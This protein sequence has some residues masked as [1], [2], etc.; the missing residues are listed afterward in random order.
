M[1]GKKVQIKDKVCEAL[2]TPIFGIVR[3]VI[4]G[5]ADVKLPQGSFLLRE[6]HLLEIIDEGE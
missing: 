2:Q 1:I 5:Y 4:N 6:I 3:A